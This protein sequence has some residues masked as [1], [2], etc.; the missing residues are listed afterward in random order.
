MAKEENKYLRESLLFLKELFLALLITFLLLLILETIFEGSVSRYLNLNHLM[1]GVAIVGVITVVTGHREAVKLKS[2]VRQSLLMGVGTGLAGALFAW[3]LTQGAGWLSG[4]A[5]AMSGVALVLLSLLLAGAAQRRQIVEALKRATR[6]IELTY[7]QLALAFVILALLKTLGLFSPGTSYMP[8]I[9]VLPLLAIPALLR[10]RHD[11]EEQRASFL[12]VLLLALVFAL[13]IR[14]VSNFQASVPLGY[15]PG[16]YKYAASLYTDN[17]PQIPEATLPLWIKRSFPQG[18]PLTLDSLY[19]F[20]GEAAIQPLSYFFP[21]LATFLILPLFMLT[22]NLFNQRIG[23]LACLLYAVS[24][25]Q[26]AASTYFYYK[27]VLAMIFLLLALH[28]VQRRKYLL[29]CLLYAAVGIYHIP[30]FILFSLILVPWFLLRRDWNIVLSAA[31]TALLLLPF[32]LPRIDAYWEVARFAAATIVQ[33]TETGA[34]SGGGAFFGLGDYGRVALPYL[35]FAVIGGLY[36]MRR[37]N[38]NSVF[39]YSVL[40]V[41][42]VVIPVFFFKRLIISLD[43]AL[44]ILAAVGISFTLTQWAS[45]SKKVAAV[46][47]IL[48]VV[49]A[50]AYTV[51][52]AKEEQPFLNRQELEAIEW[53]A[54]NSEEDAYIVATTYD[55]PWVLGWSERKVL[56]PGLFQWDTHN[57]EQWADFISAAD[58]ET[59][60]AFF[61]GY[62]GPIYIY[63]SR[64]EGSHMVLEKFENDAFEKVY[65]K[66]AVV[67]KYLGEGQPGG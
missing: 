26:Y 54:A 3:Y 12:P 57:R 8:F 67:Y 2:S 62:E 5:A 24:Y 9:L 61:E 29:L 11:A 7:L 63:Y 13:S 42:L 21:F 47:L 27:Q 53:L 20:A 43:I 58:L 50:G 23:L 33:N 36:L 55:G 52:E 31:G 6:I 46:F 64:H 37:R 49:S 45:L 48:L 18:L 16:L 25:T 66:G 22:K 4:L 60:V 51:Q 56:A 17:L 65:D 41:A 30:M 15:D 28:A 38:W 14:L 19:L 35:P 59:T 32:W 10:W 34:A 40:N 1:I 39:F 44:V